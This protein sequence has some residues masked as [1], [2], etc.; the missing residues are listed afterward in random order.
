MARSSLPF[1]ASLLAAL[2]VA[3]SS[4]AK[5]EAG[6]EIA[7]TTP[8]PSS[9]DVL[10]PVVRAGA[11]GLEVLW[12]VCRDD[13]S[14]LGAA[15]A[16]YAYQPVPVDDATRQT[17]RDNGLRLVAVRWPTS[18][19]SGTGSTSWA[20]PSAWLG[21]SLSWSE[22]FRARTL[23]RNTAVLIDGETRV[24]PRCGPRL[25]AR[26]W[27]APTTEGDRVRVELLTQLVPDSSRAAP[28]DPL[29]R[30]VSD[31]LS[32]YEL[33]RGELVASLAF[34]AEM[35]PGFAYLLVPDAPDTD[36]LAQPVVEDAT[37]ASGDGFE[38]ADDAWGM[39]VC[40]ACSARPRR[41][42]LTLGER[43]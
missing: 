22:A 25:L 14:S 17:L 37:A 42:P 40:R 16:P 41:R 38:P 28:F 18:R 39:A 7:Q 9:A 26:S 35:L 24:L 36:W 21:W 2:A 13:R 3:A 23:A 31:D 10:T 43:C 8:P 5:R 30:P 19:P 27:S 20:S 15:L 4:C 12:F 33:G 6:L 1:R 32:A 34:E 11:N 29:A